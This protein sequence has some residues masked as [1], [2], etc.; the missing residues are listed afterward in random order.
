MK[1]TLC[2][3]VEPSV[4]ERGSTIVL[5]FFLPGE[6]AK[7]FEPVSELARVFLF[8]F[9][10]LLRY[11]F[12]WN[13]PITVVILLPFLSNLYLPSSSWIS[14]ALPFPLLSTSRPLAWES[15]CLE[16]NYPLLTEIFLPFFLVVSSSSPSTT[17]P[18]IVASTFGLKVSPWFVS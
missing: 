4:A 8:Y 17:L 5:V 14:T 10:D 6:E 3:V 15:T 2:L 9:I 13:L 11:W 16:F 7:S 12:V 18:L 1:V